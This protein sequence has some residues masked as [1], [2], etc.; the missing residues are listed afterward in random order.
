MTEIPLCKSL[1]HRF[2]ACMTKESAG[3]FECNE[4]GIPS[5][6]DGY[7]NAEQDALIQC[8]N[9]SV[10]NLSPLGFAENG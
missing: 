10:V 1:A 7:C 2:V 5:I 3:H 4:A 8:L 6:K 9:G